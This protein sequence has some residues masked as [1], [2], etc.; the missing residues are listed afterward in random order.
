MDCKFGCKKQRPP[1]FEQTPAKPLPTESAERGHKK[2]R[3][4]RVLC[5][6]AGKG[7]HHFF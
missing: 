4:R 7:Q 3:Q 6:Q 2:T 1:R 5:E